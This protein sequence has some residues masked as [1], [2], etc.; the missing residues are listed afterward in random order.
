VNLNLKAIVS[1]LLILKAEE[2]MRKDLR[3]N[4]QSRKTSIKLGGVVE[5]DG[6]A[7]FSQGNTVVLATISGPAQARYARHENADKCT[8]EVEVNMAGDSAVS[9]TA[10]DLV[11]SLFIQ[12]ALSACIKLDAFPRLLI[13]VKVLVLRN[14]GSLLSTALNA[15]TLALLDASTP[16]RWFAP[17][18]ELGFLGDDTVLLDP[19][20]SE[21]HQSKATL[22][23]AMADNWVQGGMSIGGPQVVSME[24]HGDLSVQDLNRSLDQAEQFVLSLA[25]TFRDAIEKKIDTQQ[26]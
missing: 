13:V 1:F 23:V 7:Q 15:C 12:R 26:S 6:A 10:S 21:E 20:S 11:L 9:S 24:V 3:Q 2:I 14:D 25:L 16:M 17:C 8:V 5:V 18:V 4:N 22:A 19:S